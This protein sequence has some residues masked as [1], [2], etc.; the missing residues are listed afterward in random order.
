MERPLQ[1]VCNFLDALA[2]ITETMDEPAASAVNTI[3]WAAIDQVGEIDEAYPTL[4]HLSHP[5]CDRFE[6]EGWPDGH[7]S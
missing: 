7:G 2:L 5:N 4:F 6:R 1:S 3:V